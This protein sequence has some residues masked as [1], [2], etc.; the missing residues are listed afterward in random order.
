MITMVHAVGALATYS[1][2]AETQAGV[3][4]QVFVVL[5]LVAALVVI[6]GLQAVLL[7][8]PQD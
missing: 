1:D 5:G 8:R 6:A 2:L 4:A 7:W 3:G